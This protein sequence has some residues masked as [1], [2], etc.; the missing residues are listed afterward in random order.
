[1]HLVM[2]PIMT[3][4]FVG[5]HA[6]GCVDETGTSLS[7]PVSK[8]GPYGGPGASV[9]PVTA[10]GRPQTGFA[11][12][13]TAS[14]SASSSAHRNGGVEAVLRGSRPGTS[15]PT[16]AL[17][18]FVR[19][20]TASM[21]AMS[22]DGDGVGGKFIN[23]E[24]LNMRKYASRPALAKV[25]CDYILYHEHNPR[26][27]LELAAEATVQANYQDWWWKARLGKCYYQLGLLRD[28]EKQ[29]K[30]SLKEQQMIGKYD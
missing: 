29:F 11:R 4:F 7:N 25:L 3:N 21:A 1:M 10:S 23:V 6:W 12:P 30:S 8:G 15:R 14:G 16:T 24:G 18:R 22:S 27:A 19:L 17:G 13:G 2:T 20:G 28:A 5:L 9:R 26:R